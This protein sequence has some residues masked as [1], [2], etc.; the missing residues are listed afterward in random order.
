MR[1]QGA[2]KS[3]ES[4]IMS[5]GLVEMGDI[6]RSKISN[7]TSRK[8]DGMEARL[9][10]FCKITFCFVNNFLLYIKRKLCGTWS[11]K[12]ANANFLVNYAGYFC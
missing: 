12:D 4:C 10:N 1:F 6:K 7:G 8:V 3:A 2:F 5:P 9:L 11:L